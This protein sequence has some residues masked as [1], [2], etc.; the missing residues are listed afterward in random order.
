MSIFHSPVFRSPS[1]LRRVLQ[2]DAA[3][4]FA[5]GALQVAAV[6]LVS[7]WLPGLPASLLLGTGIF[8]LVYA[9]LALWTSL[10]AEVPRAMVGL[11]IV[12]NFMWAVGCVWLLAAGP[13]AMTSLG[14]AWVAMQAVVVVVLAELQWIGLRAAVP[15]SVHAQAAGGTW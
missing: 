15:S 14:F 11:F 1:F 7:S 3:S 9:A 13:F 4:C 2:V 12:G 6:S 8:L 10:R 5:S